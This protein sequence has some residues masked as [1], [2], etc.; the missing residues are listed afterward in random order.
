MMLVME[1]M[2]SDLQSCKHIADKMCKL[3]KET[4]VSV[5]SLQRLMARVR[6]TITEYVFQFTSKCDSYSKLH[7]G[8]LGKQEEHLAPWKLPAHRTK[9]PTRA[10]CV[11]S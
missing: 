3:W 2:F 8:V 7:A 1:V 5:S 4:M 9:S 11:C 6:G 10:H